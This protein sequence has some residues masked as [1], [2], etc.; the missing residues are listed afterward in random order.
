MN[1]G[2][3]VI[4]GTELPVQMTASHAGMRGG[5]CVGSKDQSTFQ[6]PNLSQMRTW[7][8]FER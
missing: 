1:V 6:R 7:R 8:Q 5:F 3:T 2:E 4:D